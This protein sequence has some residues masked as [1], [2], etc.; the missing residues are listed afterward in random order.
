MAEFDIHD[1]DH[2][3]L[4]ARRALAELERSQTNGRAFRRVL[5]FF[6]GSTSLIGATI[7][8]IAFQFPSLFQ[9]PP[10]P[11]PLLGFSATVVKLEARIDEL[12]RRQQALSPA[13]SSD[14]LRSIRQ[15]FDGFKR[16]FAEDPEK[17]LAIPMLRKDIDSLK[18]Q[19]RNDSAALRLELGRTLD[20]AKWIIGFI[21][22][23]NLG[24]G[25]LALFKKGE[26]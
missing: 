16:L 25:V 3:E 4:E 26:K 20:S 10:K 5:E 12:S 21:T 19:M 22:A 18:D 23:S 14:E 11:D 2:K 24:L 1:R 7:A 6:A 13:P 9:R 17:S 15:E 8:L